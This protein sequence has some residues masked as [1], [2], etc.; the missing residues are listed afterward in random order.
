MGYRNYHSFDDITISH[1]YEHKM[2]VFCVLMTFFDKIF[3]L[4]LISII[5]GKT[6][7]ICGSK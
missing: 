4:K 5:S 2:N 6:Y 7:S 1:Q 3:A